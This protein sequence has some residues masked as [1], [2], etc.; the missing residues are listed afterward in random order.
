[1]A[2]GLWGG[3]P[4]TEVHCA[5]VVHDVDA[6]IARVRAAGGTAEPPVQ[7]PWGRTSD[8]VDVS[9]THFAIYQPGPEPGPRPPLNG[10]RHG[11]L[12]YLTY[13]VRSS[14]QIRSFYTAVLGW[15]YT[16]GRIDDGW[17]VADV[18]PM[19]GI[20]GRADEEAIVPMWRVDDIALAVERVRAAGGTATDPEQQPYGI[21][22][23]CRDDQGMPFYLGQL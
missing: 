11:D 15:S 17:E 6:A 1:M 14:E 9:G 13:Q 21:S 22:A 7:E 23:L 8:C 19:S 16:P 10:Y 2:I 4:R 12:A 3:Q 18:V 20:G 5:Y